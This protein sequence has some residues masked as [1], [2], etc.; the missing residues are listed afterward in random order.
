LDLFVWKI[1]LLGAR[2]LASGNA[3][4]ALVELSATAA[5]RPFQLQREAIA[6][7]RRERQD[8]LEGVQRRLRQRRL[9]PNRVPEWWSEPAH[10][11]RTL[12]QAITADSQLH[13]SELGINRLN[14]FPDF[15]WAK[16]IKFPLLRTFT[17]F[18]P[19]HIS[20]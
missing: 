14:F 16:N 13:W 18:L 17:F 9:L 7:T 1:S 5:I 2:T 15:L 4:Y 3:G 11:P 10:N 12:I 6:P 19:T 20:I 8:P